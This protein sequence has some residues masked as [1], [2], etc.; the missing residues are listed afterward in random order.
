MISKLPNYCYFYVLRYFL[1]IQLRER[2][3]VLLKKVRNPLI[4]QD[5]PYVA[6]KDN[7][8]AYF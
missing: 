1:G 4:S 8:F 5:F 6:E 2:A 3:P 7:Y